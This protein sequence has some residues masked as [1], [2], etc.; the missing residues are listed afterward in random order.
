MTTP[1]QELD[2][3][4]EETEPRDAGGFSTKPCGKMCDHDSPCTL[5]LDHLP[6]SR[7]ETEHGC[8]FYDDDCRPV[9]RCNF[10]GQA[11]EGSEAIAAHEC[12]GRVPRAAAP[13]EKADDT[14][15]A[16]R[17]LYAERSKLLDAEDAGKL[18][19]AQAKLLETI[20][21]AIDALERNERDLKPSRSPGLRIEQPASLPHEI[22]FQLAMGELVEWSAGKVSADLVMTLL[23]AL[24]GA[25]GAGDGTIMDDSGLRA[26]F[27]H[28]FN[29]N[30]RERE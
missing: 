3:A 11:I 27:D 12:P 5:P 28:G 1:S 6:G 14:D 17:A 4:V 2:A 9:V 20:N 25:V 22:A 7:H 24:A 19:K 26:S 30:P 23:V 13:A 18:D 21:R 29:S 10:C 15:G 16:I 8:T